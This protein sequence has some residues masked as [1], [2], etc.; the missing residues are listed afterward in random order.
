[1]SRRKQKEME[2]SKERKVSDDELVEIAGG[3]DGPIIDP[4]G[5]SFGLPGVIGIEP[6]DDEPVE[7]N[8]LP[9]EPS[10]G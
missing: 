6:A 3:A 1:M 7:G 10:E 8:E 2:M 9:K 5:G 4:E